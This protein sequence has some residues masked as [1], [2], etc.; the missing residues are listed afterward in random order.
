LLQRADFL[1]ID[2]K[3]DAIR[4]EKRGVRSARYW[5][6]TSSIRRLAA[7]E[8]AN[9]AIT[10]VRQLH[11]NKQDFQVQEH[12]IRKDQ[13]DGAISMRRRARLRCCVRTVE[14]AVND[15]ARTNVTSGEVEAL[16]EDLQRVI[17]GRSRG[18]LAGTR[19]TEAKIVNGNQ[20][21]DTLAKLGL[22]TSE[23]A[24]LFRYS[25][26]SFERWIY[27]E[28]R[29]PPGI[30]ILLHLLLEGKV[31]IEDVRAAAKKTSRRATGG[32]P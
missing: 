27:G 26:R 25:R 11:P 22:T 29:P 17:A 21:R 2:A 3:F 5:S 6:S 12:S 8:A 31:G 4:D 23:A 10:W 24:R 20:V 16:H 19:R 28:R 15:L 14:A 32:R 7:L 18:A 9:P 1:T 13:C 30:V